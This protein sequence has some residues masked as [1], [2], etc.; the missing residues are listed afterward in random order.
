MA[1]GAVYWTGLKLYCATRTLQAPLPEPHAAAAFAPS[2]AAL[3]AQGEA[4]LRDW[5]ALSDAARDVH[6]RKARYL[7]VCAALAAVRT[8]IDALESGA[9]L[10]AR[11]KRALV[12]LPRDRGGDAADGT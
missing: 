6:E 9:V 12:L 2:A 4:L 5:H 10:G 3:Q 7:D 11:R 8:R 1:D